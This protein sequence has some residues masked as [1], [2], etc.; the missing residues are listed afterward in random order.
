MDS[1]TREFRVPSTVQD[2]DHDLVYL[3]TAQFF[4]R[5]Q[6]IISERSA[7]GRAIE[8]RRSLQERDYVG[9]LGRNQSPHWL[10]LML[11]RLQS[12]F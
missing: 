10:I 6:P 9:L 8:S 1:K 4:C 2:T 7:R 12:Y 5:A 3:K 11:L